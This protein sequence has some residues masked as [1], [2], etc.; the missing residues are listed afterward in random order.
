MGVGGQST[1]AILKGTDRLET[2]MACFFHPRKPFTH[3]QRPD[4]FQL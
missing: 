4:T 3:E 1:T 2:S